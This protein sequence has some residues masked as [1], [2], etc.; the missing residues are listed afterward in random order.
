MES[1][2]LV[3]KEKLKKKEGHSPLF[4]MCET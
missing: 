4:N 3:A 1:I 2:C